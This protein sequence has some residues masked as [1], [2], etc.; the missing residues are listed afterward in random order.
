M[1]VFKDWQELIRHALLNYSFAML[2][3]VLITATQSESLIDLIEIDSIL[4]NL[5]LLI[6]MLKKIGCRAI[7]E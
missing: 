4:L 7:E 5:A 3:I 1:K 6:A 2:S